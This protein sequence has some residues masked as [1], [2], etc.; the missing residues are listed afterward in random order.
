[1]SRDLY[2]ELRRIVREEL[3]ILHFAE[4]A[5]VQEIHPHSSADDGDNYACTVRMRDSGLVIPRVP[6]AT[7]RKG[8]ASVPDVGDLVLVQF[9]GGEVNAPLV[10]A[11]L[12]NDEDRPPENSEGDVVL[13]LPADAS[14]GEGVALRIASRS[15]TVATLALGSKVRI[16]LADDDPSVSID[17]GDGQAKLT[18]D[19]DGTVTIK[20]QKALLLEAADEICIKGNT[21]KAEA[22]TE[23]TL[24]GTM[25]N[26]N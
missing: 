15:T 1:M 26:I 8:F 14:E 21:I 7:W 6:V 11:S 5:I 10:T 9:V 17:V 12:Y 18:I 23:M 4:L 24:K 22:Q 16:E 25:I 20:S 19:G 13:R 2:Q 3:G